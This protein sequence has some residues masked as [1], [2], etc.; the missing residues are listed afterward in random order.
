MKHV[1]KMTRSLEARLVNLRQ[2]KVPSPKRPAKN[3]SRRK[4]SA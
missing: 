1:L 2:A 3:L 4:K